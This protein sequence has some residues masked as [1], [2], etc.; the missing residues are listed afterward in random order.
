MTGPSG[1][2]R[3]RLSD[4]QLHR[5][6]DWPNPAVNRRQTGVYSVWRGHEFVYVGRSD[7]LGG[8]LRSHLSG[9]RAGDQFCVYVFDRF[10]LPQL[11][12]E[13][14][15][16]AGTRRLSLDALTGEFVRASFS[17]RWV[18]VSDKEA[19]TSLEELI[20]REGLNGKLPC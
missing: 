19:A 2:L 20:R 12:R 13:Q 7:D 18:L 16:S 10:I 17:Y 4:G 11:T 14:I 15:N 8:R 5:F 6:A 3:R 9:R 1:D